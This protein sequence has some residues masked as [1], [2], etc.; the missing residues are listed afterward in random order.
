ME[1]GVKRKRDEAKLAPIPCFPNLL[2]DNDPDDAEGADVVSKE[3]V[4][5][6][7]SA[8]ERM[9]L[10]E[11]RGDD[12]DAPS[13]VMMS[14]DELSSEDESDVDLDVDADDECDSSTAKRQKIACV[15]CDL[16]TSAVVRAMDNVA[17]EWRILQSSARAQRR[18]PCFL[19]PSLS[20]T[21]HLFSFHRHTCGQSRR[22]PHHGHAAQDLQQP[23]GAA[24][25]GG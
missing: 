8:A 18:S 21:T 13:R 3:A 25:R 17:G 16:A 24:A 10:H 9:A 1:N 14:G 4:A 23:N 22:R 5:A 6:R 19:S 15:C 20:L 12:A 7:L 11:D 2:E